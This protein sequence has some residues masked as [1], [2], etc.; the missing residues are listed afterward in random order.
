MRSV[1]HSTA[2]NFFQ[3]RTPPNAFRELPLAAGPLL[4]RLECGY[5]CLS[6]SDG[7]LPQLHSDRS[8]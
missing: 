1:N 3:I 4:Q 5:R 2:L 8:S 7:S 6:N